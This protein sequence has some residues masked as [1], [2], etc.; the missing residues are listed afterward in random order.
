MAFAKRI[1]E[2]F[3][4]DSDVA[5]LSKESMSIPIHSVPDSGNVTVEFLLKMDDEWLERIEHSVDSD[6]FIPKAKNRGKLPEME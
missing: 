2:S 6:R 5:P 1:D 3:P 4:Y